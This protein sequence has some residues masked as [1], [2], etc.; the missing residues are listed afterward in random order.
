MFWE[1]DFP[2][3]AGD[4]DEKISML[5]LQ[6]LES[7]IPPGPYI[8]VMDAGLLGSYEAAKYL[9]TNG[10]SFIMS[11][12][13]TRLAP[14]WTYLKEVILVVFLYNNIRILDHLNG[15]QHLHLF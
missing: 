12:S 5:Y 13:G 11:C 14:L 15:S 8:F 3:E 9:H 6:E 7:N 2:W 4:G 10:R 1:L